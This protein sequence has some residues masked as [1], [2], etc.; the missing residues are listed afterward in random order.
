I[1]GGMILTDDAELARLCRIL[2]AHGW[3]RDVATAKCFEDEY[4][5][6]LFGWNVRPLELHAAI[7][8][9]QLKKLDRFVDARNV[10]ADYFEQRVE[11]YQLPVVL[12][13]KSG[14]RRSPF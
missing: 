10:N 8:R 1:E 13:T 7:A 2:R 12:P 9:A 4:D 6:R 14:E 5:F 3:T 11:E